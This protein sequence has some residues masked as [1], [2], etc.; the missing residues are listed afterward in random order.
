M[1]AKPE[2]SFWTFVLASVSQT[3][4]KER[5]FILAHSLGDFSAC[6][7]TVAKQLVMAGTR[8]GAELSPG[9]KNCSKERG[10]R[11]DRLLLSSPRHA[12]SDIR[13]SH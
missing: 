6:F 1:E 8:G 2:N 10:Q 12:P 11:R 4:Y 9:E 5:K 13:S 7:G 3:V